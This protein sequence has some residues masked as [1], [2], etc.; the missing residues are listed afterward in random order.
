MAGA[1]GRKTDLPALLALLF[2]NGAESVNQTNIA[3]LNLP[4]SIEFHQTLYG[5]GILS[6]LFFVGYGLFE[7]PAGVLATRV[8]VRKIAILGGLVTSLAA[9]AS[10]AAPNFASLVFL[11]FVIGAALGLS[12]PPIVVLIIRSLKSGSTGLGASLVLVS[13]LAASALG[14]F[15]TSLLAAAAGW[16]ISLFIAGAL[17]LVSVI[18]G[19]KFA[20][21]DVPVSGRSVSM[22]AFRAVVRDRQVLILGISFVGVGAA[23]SLTG[24]FLVY[25]LEQ[26][27]GVSPAYAGSIG[28]LVY[29]FPIATTS[30]FG[31]LYDRGRNERLLMVC[32]AAL[33]AFGVAITALDSVYSALL[34]AAIVGSASSVFFTIGFSVARDRSPSPELESLTIAFADSFNFVGFFFAPLYFSLLVLGYGYQLAWLVGAVPAVVI[35]IPVLRLKKRA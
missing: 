20:A 5:L 7:L 2:L 34:S 17:C 30:Y 32:A 14:V 15:G 1:E 12:F 8:G 21:T 28:A 22:A 13:F 35:V 9:I 16:R 6:S 27:L 19:M 29:V 4:I 31:R 24:S 10:A 11:R 23:T 18:V 26:H 25:Y 33:V 3:P